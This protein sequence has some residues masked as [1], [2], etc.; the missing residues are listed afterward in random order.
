MQPVWKN[1]RLPA[2]LTG[3]TNLIVLCDA[4]RTEQVQ[5]HL[6]YPTYWSSSFILYIFWGKRQVRHQQPWLSHDISRNDEKRPSKL[7]ICSLTST[8]GLWS[9]TV[10][11]TKR[12]KMSN[13]SVRCSPCSP[14]PAAANRS[15]PRSSVR[16]LEWSQDHCRQEGLAG[17]P[18]KTVKTMRFQDVMAISVS[19][20]LNYCYRYL[21]VGTSL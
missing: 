3:P 7:I 1:T 12:L 16:R 10:F 4:L 9:K 2:A 18:S 5:R 14:W 6:F 17:R 21:N 19:L 15:H 11:E 13:I 20:S 8:R